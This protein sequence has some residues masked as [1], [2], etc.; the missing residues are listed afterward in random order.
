VDKGGTKY[1]G[2]A[3]SGFDH[4]HSCPKPASPLTPEAFVKDRLDGQGG[5]GNGIG[6]YILAQEG[7]DVLCEM[8]SYGAKVRDTE[9]AF[10][11]AEFRDPETK[12]L[13]SDDYTNRY[14]IITWGRTFKPALYEE[15]YRSGVDLH[16]WIM[17]TSLLTEGGVQGGRVVGATGFNVRTG[18]FYIFRAKA[19]ILCMGHPAARGWAFSTELQ[20]LGG[21]HGPG[22]GSGDGESMA[23]RA[24]AEFTLMEKTAVVRRHRSTTEG[25]YTTSWFPCSVVD[26]E[27]KEVPY[28]NDK[29]EVLKTISERVHPDPAE[30]ISLVGGPSDKVKGRGGKPALP[31]DLEQRIANGEFKLPLYCDFPSMPEHERRAIYGFKIA[32]E[33]TT[34]LAYHNMTRAGFDPEKH[35]LQVYD[36][37]VRGGYFGWHRLRGGGVLIDWELKTTLEGL[38]AAGDQ[39]FDGNF[40]SHALATGRYAAR[41]AAAYA[42]T[43]SQPQID[44]GQV[45]AEKDRVYAPVLRQRGVEWK[46]IDAG[47][48]NVMQHYCG[49][50]KSDE[51]LKLG[52]LWMDELRRGEAKALYARNPHELVRC[53]EIY[54]LLD[55]CEA[56]L[57]QS[58]A[59]KS[60]NSWMHLIRTDYPENDPPQWRKW[61]TTKL[62]GGEVKTRDLPMDFWGDLE[63]NYKKHCR[64]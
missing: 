34:W 51:R 43:A 26:A 20:G 37:P 57:H 1:S 54:C 27:G 19:I 46:E 4:W 30:S 15:L 38:Y 3:G 10:E 61:I 33:G 13:F 28:I 45:D 50:T 23:W 64:L 47:L 59:R 17:I 7:Y 48:S 29:G 62:L 52:L 12:L 36:E 35:L 58:L 5:Y 16:Q 55:W 8:E 63:A 18:E 6:Y 9:G 39:I 21:R 11:G 14:T 32:Q 22:L 60:S 2:F 44:R 42:V 56:V 31:A 40:V 25:S 24:G 49:D 41:Q 53:L